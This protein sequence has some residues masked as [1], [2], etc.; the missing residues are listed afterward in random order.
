MLTLKQYLNESLLIEANKSDPRQNPPKFDQSEKRNNKK[1]WQHVAK[2]IDDK[3]SSI[4]KLLAQLTG[5]KN[6]TI[7]YA[8][9]YELDGNYYYRT[10]IVYKLSGTKQYDRN[11]G[12]EFV[13]DSSNNQV[14]IVARKVP[15]SLSN[16]LDTAKKIVDAI[17]RDIE[18]SLNQIGQSV[19]I[20]KLDSG[21]QY[22]YIFTISQPDYDKCVKGGIRLAANLNYQRMQLRKKDERSSDQVF[23]LLTKMQ[24]N[25][26]KFSDRTKKSAEFVKQLKKSP[27]YKNLNEALQGT[28]FVIANFDK[29]MF[30]YLM[31]WPLKWYFEFYILD[32]SAHKLYCLSEELYVKHDKEFKPNQTLGGYFGNINF[33]VT[34]ASLI[35]SQ[36][37]YSKQDLDDANDINNM[38]QITAKQAAERLTKA[39]EQ[40]TFRQLEKLNNQNYL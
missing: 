14:R 11:T 22:G 36:G 19:I 5:D 6:C 4:I 17:D 3:K 28:N 9:M 40:I 21:R 34:R 37:W 1:L 23:D 20:K 8:P 26:N 30:G 12:V 29:W 33:K 35:K 32:K 39:I 18:R 38:D 16:A 31:N 25:N 27:I 24:Q 13:T 2:A 15:G 10:E 7:A